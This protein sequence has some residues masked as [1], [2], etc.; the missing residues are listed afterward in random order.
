MKITLFR[1]RQARG[2]PSSFRNIFERGMKQRG[3]KIIWYSIFKSNNNIFI[4][5]GTKRFLELFLFKLLGSKIIQRL[6]PIPWEHKIYKTTFFKYLLAEIR[7]YLVIFIRLFIA[8]EFIYQSKYT[9]K[10]WDE[11]YPLKKKKKSTIIY[12]GANSIFY[13][14]KKNNSVFCNELVACEGDIINFLSRYIFIKNKNY[15]LNVFGY[16]PKNVLNIKDINSNKSVKFYGYKTKE[17]VS[18]FYKKNLIFL[19]LELHPACPNSI[20]EALASG[21]PVIGFNT[22]SS[23][24]IISSD[25]GIVI[26]FEKSKLLSNNLND[27]DGLFDEINFAINKIKNNYKFYSDNAMLRYK[28]KYT[29]EIMLDNYYNFLKSNFKLK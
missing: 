11:N 20:L 6:G 28:D 16:V 12:N 26:E 21:I 8:T 9:Q 24:E 18:S 4:I 15:T 19:S 14:L 29:S 10:I 3:F 27:M 2:G 1:T 5:N 13:G 25:V 17:F 22:G 23:K 7:K